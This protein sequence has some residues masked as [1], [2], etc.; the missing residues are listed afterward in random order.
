MLRTLPKPYRKGDIHRKMGIVVVGNTHS[1]RKAPEAASR[2]TELKKQPFNHSYPEHALV[3]SLQRSNRIAGFM[4]TN[5]FDGTTEVIN[6]VDGLLLP[7][8]K[9]PSMKQGD[10]GCLL[11]HQ[12]AL[13]YAKAQGWDS[14]L[15]FEDDAKPVADFN[16]KLKEA[17][18]QLPA[19]WDMLWLGGKDNTLPLSYSP[20]LKL[21]TGSWGTYGYV[22]RSTVYDFFINQFEEQFQSS[23]EYYR[24][25]HSEFNCFRTEQDLVHHIIGT[26]DRIT[27][28][29]TANGR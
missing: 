1:I 8:P 28:N 14:V 9:V 29:K 16:R 20:K 10:V 26:S 25:K 19:N 4:A 12:K 11:S 27:I 7:P 5:T 24:R 13:Q 21:L 18:S 15:I 3:I 22:I 6:A 17:M 2:I 23:D